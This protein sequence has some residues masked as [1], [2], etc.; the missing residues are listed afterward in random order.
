MNGSQGSCDQ[1]VVE[2]TSSYTV[3]SPIAGDPQMTEADTSAKDVHQNCITNGNTQNDTVNTEDCSKVKEKII[4]ESQKTPDFTFSN[5]HGCREEAVAIKMPKKKRNKTSTKSRHNLAGEKVHS[6]LVVKIRNEQSKRKTIIP[7]THPLKYIACSTSQETLNG[8]HKADDLSLAPLNTILHNVQQS[9]S[10]LH[11]LDENI[12]HDDQS[13]A[14]CHT[15]VNNSLYDVLVT[16]KQLKPS[17]SGDD[18]LPETFR[19]QYYP[20]SPVSPSSAVT[21]RH[22]YFVTCGDCLGDSAASRLDPRP[23]F[24][25]G[26]HGTQTLHYDAYP[27]VGKC[28]DS[29]YCCPS[30]SGGHHGALGNYDSVCSVSCSTS[31]HCPVKNVDQGCDSCSS[32]TGCRPETV[33]VGHVPLSSRPT[34]DC[35]FRSLAFCQD[36]A[37][38]G[39]QPADPSLNQSPTTSVSGCAEWDVIRPVPIHSTRHVYQS[40]DVKPHAGLLTHEDVGASQ[41]HDVHVDEPTQTQKPHCVSSDKS[42]K[43]RKG[44]CNLADNSIQPLK[45]YYNPPG[46]STYPLKRYYD[47]H[48]DTLK[49]YYSSTIESVRPRKRSYDQS[50]SIPTSSTECHSSD[51]DVSG[52]QILE[53]SNGSCCSLLN[54]ESL[55]LVQVRSCAVVPNEE[56]K[57]REP[58]KRKR[59]TFHSRFSAYSAHFA[60]YC[61][62]R[63]DELAVRYLVTKYLD[64]IE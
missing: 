20:S 22:D 21:P 30:G 28:L 9:R 23:S 15:R 13:C 11:A 19:H 60:H 51:P 45:R 27:D 25:G 26:A 8:Q 52:G 64:K 54:R 49:W 38:S 3:Q 34:T 2:T 7:K 36:R 40:E 6:T 1:S 14:T 48:S 29:V 43:P 46:E 4:F 5:K 56:H 39:D 61:R 58:K 55:N 62:I 41:R 12:T 63:E 16:P 42:T 33:K 18:D 32:V 44:S 57:K 53:T 35:L 17:V 10:Y 37:N 59:C 47:P 31:R 24:S 50:E